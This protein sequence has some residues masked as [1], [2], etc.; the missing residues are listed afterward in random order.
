MKKSLL[1]LALL[2]SL[3]GCTIQKSKV[4]TMPQYL[5]VQ[6]G[7]TK[8][9]IIEKFGEPKSIEVRDDGVEVYFYMEQLRINGQVVEMRHY[10]FYIKD[11]VVIRK[12]LQVTTKPSEF[13]SDQF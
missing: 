8:Q 12:Y 4:V 10:Y 5:K 2:I 6:K 13:T 3:C 7:E 1:K 11:D 9:D